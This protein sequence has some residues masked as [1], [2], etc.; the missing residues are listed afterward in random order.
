MAWSNFPPQGSKWQFPLEGD[1]RLGRPCDS[2]G[3]RSAHF[4]HEE[5]K[6]PCLQASPKNGWNCLLVNK[7]L[8]I[9]SF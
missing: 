6:T 3:Q 9:V 2:S 5:M 8:G 1:C 4:S 7:T